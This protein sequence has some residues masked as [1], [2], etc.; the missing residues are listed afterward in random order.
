MGG[1]GGEERRERCTDELHNKVF[2]LRV[3]LSITHFLQRVVRNTR[4]STEGSTNRS[5]KKTNLHEGVD[6]T[7]QKVRADRRVDVVLE[8]LEGT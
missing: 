1:G 4:T 7:Q 5:L 2:V 6:L 3:Q 8:A